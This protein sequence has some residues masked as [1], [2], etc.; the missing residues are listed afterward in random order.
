M[1][2]LYFF[3]FIIFSLVHLSYSGFCDS[4]HS[5]SNTYGIGKNIYISQGINSIYIY[6]LKVNSISEKKYSAE[7]NQNKVITKE[8]IPKVE[9]KETSI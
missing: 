3:T 7:N 5:I 8:S 9:S 2:E 6:D 4:V 1:F